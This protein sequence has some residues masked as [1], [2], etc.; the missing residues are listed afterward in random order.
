MI[1][2]AMPVAAGIG[3]LVRAFDPLAYAG[4]LGIIVATCLVAAFF[5]ARRA[6]RIDPMAALRAD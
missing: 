5:P 4:S 3:T 2:L 1:L 6:A